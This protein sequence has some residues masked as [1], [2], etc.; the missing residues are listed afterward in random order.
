LWYL[1]T[2]NAVCSVII[3]EEAEKN[4]QVEQSA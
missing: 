2:D 3:E 4:R 1:Q